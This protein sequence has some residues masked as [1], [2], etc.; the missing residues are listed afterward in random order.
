MRRHHWLLVG[1]T[2]ILVA[3]WLLWNVILVES[4]VPPPAGTAANAPSGQP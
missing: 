4:D 1:A 2:S 3:G